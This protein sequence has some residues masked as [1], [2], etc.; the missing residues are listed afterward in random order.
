MY[1]AY[2]Y[3]RIEYACIKA[4]IIRC[5]ILWQ[6]SH[7]AIGWIYS[8]NTVHTYGLKTTSPRREEVPLL[9]VL[10]CPLPRG[11]NQKRAI[12]KLLCAVGEYKTTAFNLAGDAYRV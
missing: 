5:Y 10:G 7:S 11:C 3:I 12:Q 2:P 8:L 4:Y 1:N 6:V 9:K